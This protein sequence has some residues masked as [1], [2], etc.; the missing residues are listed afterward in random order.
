MSISEKRILT[1]LAEKLQEILKN[2]IINLF[3]KT[4]YCIDDYN[5]IFCYLVDK[6]SEKEKDDLL[7]IIIDMEQDLLHYPDELEE[8]MKKTNEDIEKLEKEPIFCFY[9]KDD[10]PDEKKAIEMAEIIKKE[11]KIYFLKQKQKIFLEKFKNHETII[12]ERK[13]VENI[14]KQTEIIQKE[15]KKKEAEKEEKQIDF[16]MK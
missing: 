12:N 2:N 5:D 14:K 7:D 6:I 10:T 1:E 9:D 15:I 13:K 11:A 3:D 4:E 8:F 16:M